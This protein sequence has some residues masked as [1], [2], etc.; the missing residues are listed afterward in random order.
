[1]DYRDPIT[2][3]DQ[4]IENLTHLVDW[5]LEDIDAG[6]LGGGLLAKDT[7]R[8]IAALRAIRAVLPRLRIVRSNFE[9]QPNLPDASRPPPDQALIDYIEESHAELR[10]RL[11]K[12]RGGSSNFPLSSDATYKPPEVRA[13]IAMSLHERRMGMRSHEE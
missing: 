13:A 3:I 9:S 11:N 4:S 10:K 12:P 1:M 6:A 2:L 5:L 7:I 8:S